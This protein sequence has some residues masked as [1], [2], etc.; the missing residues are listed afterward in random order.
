MTRIILL[1]EC[2]WCGGFN[3][4]SLHIHIPGINRKVAWY[5]KLW[6]LRI[7]ITHGI[8]G[9]CRANL[10]VDVGRMLD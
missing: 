8:C 9:E 4:C 2:A 3:F 5:V 7:G 1:R 10:K 6:G